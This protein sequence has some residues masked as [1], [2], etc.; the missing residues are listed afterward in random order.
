MEPYSNVEEQTNTFASMKTSTDFTEHESDVTPLKDVDAELKEVS[1][2]LRTLVGRYS[3]DQAIK[4]AD[5]EWRE[6]ALV[7]DR[8]LF[9]MFSVMFLLTTLS[10]LS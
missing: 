2:N 9:L 6:I 7:V 5:S 1:R 4:E 8:L 10:I 3:T